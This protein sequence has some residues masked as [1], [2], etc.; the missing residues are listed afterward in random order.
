MR[1]KYKKTSY[2]RS[3]DTGELDTDLSSGGDFSL[4]EILAEY[5]GGRKQRL[6]DELERRAVRETGAE[7]PPGSS[8][9][10]PSGSPEEAEAAPAPEEPPAEETPPRD[11]GAE[12]SPDRPRPSGGVPQPDVTRSEE[13]TPPQEAPADELPPSPRPISMEEVVRRTVDEVIEE[14][15]EPLLPPRR[16]LFS[17]KKPADT[18]ELYA[19][20]E[21]EP[22]QP[23]PEETI[24]PEPD[25]TD[26][27]EDGRRLSVRSGR[28]LSAVGLLCAVP[29][30][31]LAAEAAGLSVP[32]WT[33]HT[34]LQAAVLAVV[35]LLVCVLGRSVFVRGF[36]ALRHGR[37]TGELL[38]SLAALVTLADC[39]SA[40][41]LSGRSAVPPYAA[42]VSA[43]FLFALWGGQRLGRGRYDTFRTAAMEDPPY[44]ITDIP[45]G[46][47]KQRGRAEGFYTCAS[48]ADAASR[49]QA[50]LLPV[51]L[52]A[53]VVFAGLSS[54][55]GQGR[56]QNF[57]LNWSAIL[58]AGASFA[59]PLA[60]ALPFS[61]LARRL[62]K[63][64][65]AV[66]GYDGAERISR[67]RCLILTD[68]DLFPPGTISLNG[69]KTYGE[70]LG[71]VVSYAATLARASGCGL[72]RLFDGLLRSEG[73][74]YENLTDFSFYEEG[75][76]SGNIR[77]ETVL[78]GTASFLRKMEVRLP[79][80]LKLHTGIFLAVDRQLIAVFAVKYQ[81]SENV[82]WALRLLR[83]NRILPILAA[84]DPNL[85]PTLL[86][87][88]FSKG[89]KV[90]YPPLSDRVALSEQEG[91][92]G[93]PRALL[94]REGLLPYAD[95][96]VGG[97]RLCRAVRR[98]TF[99]S[100]LGSVSGTLLAFYL[101]F[102]GAYDLLTPLSLLVFLLLWTLPVLLLTDWTGRF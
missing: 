101:T 49:W 20:P 92:Q 5:G 66:A 35:L 72:E 16:G 78:M 97:R 69:M 93:L 15:D 51:V 25:L 77:G 85:T 13:E 42:A 21:P 31:L 34:D 4:E 60:Y 38:T 71:K 33:G 9:P 68:T 53:S 81:P 70:T 56:P 75:G 19:K 47:C 7:E 82:D 84:R 46:A 79:G 58:T 64:G 17:R 50:A 44:L 87:R 52:T 32:L 55:G 41:L 18:E 65:C 40:P 27:A 10:E 73:G 102:L 100:L 63:T 11:A 83:R 45:R 26:E 1:S 39:L 94:Y 8:E 88:K 14:T 80:N 91:A 43:G 99:F 62:Q 67:G 54:F 12:A 61:R 22:E 29:A 37:C 36:R 98:S 95:A 24:G 74:T 2:S 48:R 28:P 23:E 90:E 59:L 86:K 76:F 96:A 57:L 6:L 3:A 30:A 89:V